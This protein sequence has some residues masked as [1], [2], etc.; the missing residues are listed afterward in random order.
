MVRTKLRTWSR[1]P[2]KREHEA[3]RVA[4]EKPGYPFGL[5]PR[6]NSQLR[7]EAPL[8]DL[9]VPVPDRLMVDGVTSDEA[10]DLLAFGVA[11]D[12]RLS[13]MHFDE[14]R[15]CVHSARASLL[16]A[17][18][19]GTLSPVVQSPASKAWWRVP[20][21]YWEQPSSA[22]LADVIR[23]A[24]VPDILPRHPKPL[25]PR[26]AINVHSYL[27]DLPSAD[28]IGQMLV[29]RRSEIEG[30]LG[31]VGAIVDQRRAAAVAITTLSSG[32]PVDAPAGQS[33]VSTEIEQSIHNATGQGE[34]SVD[35]F[36]DEWQIAAKLDAEGR[37]KRDVKSADMLRLWDGTGPTPLLKN[38]IASMTNKPK[39]RRAAATKA[40]N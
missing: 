40:T 8:P 27:H 13:S 14:R 2:R 17:L 24:V 30:Y 6:M 33:P 34:A 22:E 36:S 20:A 7:W 10:V 3:A 9:F 18:W 31:I 16:M 23:D 25:H 19:D 32:V 28:V 35:L 12:Q 37:S 39:G 1:L 38:V 26:Y 29:Y 4:P 11:A 15:A 5:P 21:V